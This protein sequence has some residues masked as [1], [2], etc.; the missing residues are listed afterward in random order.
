MY[1]NLSDEKRD[2][3]RRGCSKSADQVI[4][5]AG[6]GGLRWLML[7]GMFA[8]ALRFL[9]GEAEQNNRGKSPIQSPR[10]TKENETGFWVTL[11][12]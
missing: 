7:H 11:S 5:G 6:S 1:T 12:E 3:S 2:L 8:G 4:T 10:T 9:P